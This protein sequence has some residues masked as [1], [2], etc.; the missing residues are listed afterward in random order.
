M[1]MNNSYMKQ[2]W[3]ADRYYQGQHDT[4]RPEELLEIIVQYDN[5]NHR[6]FHRQQWEII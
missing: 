1:L 6:S 3:I 2:F 4:R 5:I